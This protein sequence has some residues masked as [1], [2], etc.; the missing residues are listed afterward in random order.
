MGPLTKGN[1]YGCPV[2]RLWKVLLLV[3]AVLVLLAILGGVGAPPVVTV[4]ALI[5][6]VTIGVLNRLER[7]RI[8]VALAEV[9][10]G[11]R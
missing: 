1:G 4:F 9:E 7:E 8:G 3:L 10:G 2:R 11:S 5:A 6:T